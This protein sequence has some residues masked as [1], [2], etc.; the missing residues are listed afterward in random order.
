MKEKWIIDLYPS[1]LKSQSLH[2]DVLYSIDPIL[3][4][5]TRDKRTT[6]HKIN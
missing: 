1:L 5:Q 3:Q 2:E 6:S 4:T